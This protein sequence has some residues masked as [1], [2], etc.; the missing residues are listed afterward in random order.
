MDLYWFYY[1]GYTIRSYKSKRNGLIS[2]F[3]DRDNDNTFSFSNI[4]NMNHSNGGSN[5]VKKS[6]NRKSKI[7]IIVD[8]IL[9][10]WTWIMN[11]VDSKLFDIK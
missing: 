4:S 1:L 9:L 7:K 6:T 3:V 11:I 5:L 2:E 8:Q 10:L